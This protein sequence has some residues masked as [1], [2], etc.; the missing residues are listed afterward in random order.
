MSN[1][2]A[3]RLVIF[4]FGIWEFLYILGSLGMLSGGRLMNVLR[5]DWVLEKENIFQLGNIDKFSA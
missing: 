2:L 1:C 5:S 3:L 4:Q